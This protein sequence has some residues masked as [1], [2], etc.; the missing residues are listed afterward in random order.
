MACLLRIQYQM[1]QLSSPIQEIESMQVTARAE[2]IKS[3]LLIRK[4]ETDA[5]LDQEFL[6]YTPE[7]DD[8]CRR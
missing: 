2:A 3:K 1:N 8:F 4:S 6:S 5:V 7:V